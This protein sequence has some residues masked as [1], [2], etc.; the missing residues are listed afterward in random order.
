MR[1]LKEQGIRRTLASNARV[2]SYEEFAQR[3]G[4]IEVEIIRSSI[5]G[6]TAELHDSITTINGSFEQ[7]IEGFKNI[8]KYDI[9]LMVNVV[10]LK[11][12]YKHLKA[13]TSML[14]ELGVREIKYASLILRNSGYDNRHELAVKISESRPYL[15]EALD[16]AESSGVNFVIEKNPICIAPK[17][18]QHFIGESDPQMNTDS[19]FAKSPECTKCRFNDKCLGVSVRYQ[20]LFGLSELKPL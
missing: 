8:I 20:E 1:Y 13:I 15:N 2:F 7:S 11:P 18:H 10:I 9:P 14:V 3:V 17:Y 12:N 16:L 19:T 6:H 5:Y 4:I